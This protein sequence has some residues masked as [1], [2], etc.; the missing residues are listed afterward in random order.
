MTAARNIRKQAPGGSWRSAN[1]PLR[2]R[3][4]VLSLCYALTQIFWNIN[5]IF[6]TPLL[7]RF[8]TPL[9]A[10]QWG[11]GGK[12]PHKLIWGDVALLFGKDCIRGKDNKGYEET[13]SE[14]LQVNI[15]QFKVTTRTCVRFV[16][17][18][19]LHAEGSSIRDRIWYQGCIG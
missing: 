9:R 19:K 11:F 5:S 12:R 17:V 16:P 3:G 13:T 4:D 1:A 7:S 10:T 2:R 6:S 18:T 15:L 8:I 14:G